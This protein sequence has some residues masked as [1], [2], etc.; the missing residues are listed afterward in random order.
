MW[1]VGWRGL[2]GLGSEGI[3]DRVCRTELAKSIG[4]WVGGV[5]E[6]KGWRV[7]FH[8]GGIG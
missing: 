5:A 6:R 4:S 8:G 1:L 3:V 2:V 7:N